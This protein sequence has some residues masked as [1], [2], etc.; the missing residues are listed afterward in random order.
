MRLGCEGGGCLVC[1]RLSPGHCSPRCRPLVL[2]PQSRG[3]ESRRAG[4]RRGDCGYNQAASG[5]GAFRGGATPGEPQPWGILV[6][7]EALFLGPITAQEGEGPLAALLPEEETE[8]QRREGTVPG[9][10]KSGSRPRVCSQLSSPRFPP[11]A[12]PSLSFSLAKQFSSAWAP[13]GG[14][15]FPPQGHK[16]PES[17]GF[18][19]LGDIEDGKYQINY[20]CI[21]VGNLRLLKVKTL[22]IAPP[23]LQASTNLSALPHRPLSLHAQVIDCW[24]RLGSVKHLIY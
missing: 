20:F 6:M 1:G 17:P 5:R 8:A 21:A 18:T 16:T 3:E 14:T 13:A 22:P 23:R 9:S 4:D 12:S 2:A 24:I 11:G 10:A 7:D 15:P 19:S